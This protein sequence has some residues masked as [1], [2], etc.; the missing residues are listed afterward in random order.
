MSAGLPVEQHSVLRSIILHL[1]PGVLIILFMSVTAPIL[2]TRNYPF[3]V[4]VLLSIVLVAIPFELGYL[5]Y[6]GTRKKEGVTLRSVILYRD[7]LPSWQYL[8]IA[9]P[10]LIWLV[11]VFAVLSPPIDKYLIDELF[12][13]LPA[14]LLCDGDDLNRYPDALLVTIAVLSVPLNGIAAPLVEELYFRGYLLPRVSRFGRWAP[15]LNTVL[16]SFYHFFSP[17]QNPAR[18]IGLLPMTYAVWHR[19]NIYLGIIVHCGANTLFTLLAIL[20]FVLQ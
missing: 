10:S 2:E 5:L 12:F 7:R 13:W 6:Q 8:T 20:L 15:V 17:W 3:M 4:T 9:I 11:L 18:I 16:F 14:W 19:R 1:L